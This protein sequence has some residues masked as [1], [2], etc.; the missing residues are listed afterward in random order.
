[1][2]H[3]SK[4]KGQNYVFR[5]KYR[6]IL[7]KPRGSQKFLARTIT[8]IEKINKEDLIKTKNFSLQMT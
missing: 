5:R 7:L 8:I 3:K 4:Y 1:M 6:T 2:N